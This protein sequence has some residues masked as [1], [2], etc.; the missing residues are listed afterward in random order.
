MESLELE[1]PLPFMLWTNFLQPLRDSRKEI[2][3][4]RR[5]KASVYLLLFFF[6]YSPTMPGRAPFSLLLVLGRIGFDLDA[7]RGRR[8]RWLKPS[9][10]SQDQV[11][12]KCRRQPSRGSS[13]SVS[14]GAKGTNYVASI[15]PTAQLPAYETGRTDSP[16]SR[17]RHICRPLVRAS[18]GG[19]LGTGCARLRT[20]IYRHSSCIA[21]QVSHK[22]QGCWHQGT[23][24]PNVTEASAMGK[25]LWSRDQAG[26]APRQ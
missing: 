14:V 16:T 25:Q 24:R 13:G 2:A 12:S 5:R 19:D 11:S 6:R 9:A 15:R 18:L 7:K 8:W 4:K 23:R 17:L 22:G 3:T 20:P 21:A 10:P 1:P 26:V